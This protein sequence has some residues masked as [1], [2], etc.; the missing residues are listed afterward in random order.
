MNYL[1]KLL[2]AMTLAIAG[3]HAQAIQIGPGNCDPTGCSTGE[4]TSISELDDFLQS[5]LGLEELYT[6]SVGSNSDS[7]LFADSYTTTFDNLPASPSDALIA[8]VD[9]QQG[10]SCLECYLLVMDNDVDPAAW[11]L[12]NLGA[13][14]W[15]S[16]SLTGFWP[17]AGAISYV[18]IYGRQGTSV[19]QSASVAAPA[20]LVLLT[21]GLLLSGLRRLKAS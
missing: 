3:S 13:W 14:G 12:F 4:N 5:M 18:T 7:G 20:P 17:E 8:R 19:V 9:G 16:I 10:I 2:M 21:I 6:S 1:I 11:Y 15:D